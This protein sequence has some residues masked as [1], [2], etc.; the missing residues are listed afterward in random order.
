MH[1]IL[2]GGGLDEVI[3]RPRLHHQLLPMEIEHEAEFN[4]VNVLHVLSE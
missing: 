1:T 2:E 3:Q 4:P